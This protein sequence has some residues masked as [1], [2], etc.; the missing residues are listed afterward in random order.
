MKYIVIGIGKTKKK[1]F[2]KLAVEIGWD[3]VDG[4]S[5]KF[6]GKPEDLEVWLKSK[7]IRVCTFCTF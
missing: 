4:P 3:K 5:S 1:D 7:K 2:G 6:L